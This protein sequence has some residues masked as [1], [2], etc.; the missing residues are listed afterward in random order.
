MARSLFQQRAFR[1]E[2]QISSSERCTMINT[3]WNGESEPPSSLPNQ[4]RMPLESVHLRKEIFRSLVMLQDHGETVKISR[5]R[6]S[7]QYA[8][9][10]EE[11]ALIERE[12]IAKN[13]LPL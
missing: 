11:L 8:I 2:I 7:V 13:W 4:S 5:I 10:Q 6:V 3:P 9:S 12:G 1:F